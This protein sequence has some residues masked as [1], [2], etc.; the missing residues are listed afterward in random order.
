MEIRRFAERI[1][2]GNTLEDKLLSLDEYQDE[3]PGQALGV[4][5]APG[6]PAALAL[7]QYHQRQRVRFAELRRFHTEKERGLVL[8]FFANHELL[9]LE[10]M[11]LALLRFP[12]APDKFRRGLVQTLRDEQEHVRLYLKRLAQVGVEFGQ[13]PVSDFF[14]RAI[15]PS[16]SP[17]DFVA[18]L[19]LTLEQANL[20]YARHYAA[21]YQH[22]GDEDTARI[23]GRIYRDEIGHVKHGLVWFNRWRDPALSEW[24]AYQGVLQMPL[25]PSRAKGIGFN[26]EGRLEAGLSEAFID[27]LELY[28]RSKGRC[29]SVFWFDPSCESQVI[30]PGFTP[31]RSVRQLAQDLALLPL[32]L[33][34]PDDVVLVPRRPSLDFLR[35]LSRAGFAI[36][37]LVEHPLGSP[38]AGELAQRKLSDLRP[39][40]W[41]PQVERV[42]APLR[43]QL[44]L[45]QGW[46]EQ[47]RALYSKAWSTAALRDFLRICN[48]DWLAD[49]QVVGQACANMEEV[50]AQ[51]ARRAAEGWD[52][53]VV[54][55]AFGAAGQSQVRLA[56]LQSRADQLAQV[57]RLL[58]TQG[59]VVVEPWLD[60]LVDLSAQLEISAPG[61]ARLLGWTRFFTDGRGQYRGSF[62]SQPIA[63][64]DQSIRRFLCGEGRDQR[65]LWRFFEGLGEFLAERLADSGYTGPL[66]VDALIFRQQGRLRL[67]PIVE[68]NPRFTMGRVALGLARRVNAS[69][70]ALWLI[71]GRRQL[72]SAGFAGIAPFAVHLE[73]QFPVEMKGEHISQGVLFTTDPTQAQAFATLLLVGQSLEECKESFAGLPGK[74]GEWMKYC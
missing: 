6:R 7:D 18:R 31:S 72:E 19:S 40:G 21:A 17:L 66:G 10:L 25:T 60:K 23:L 24:E 68:I 48:E 11:A 29:P 61:Q 51:L 57:A 16:P 38:L 53:A 71:L 8:H 14:W 73:R 44:A 52:L 43:E 36:P 15:A 54:K 58:E 67:K 9:A 39:W 22:L 5:A 4:P 33:C 2:F 27:E 64:L 3:V 47:W 42:A 46:R 20:D 62:V 30:R 34:A 69:R 63:G 28:A 70:T 26:R 74:A 55:G 41:S 65:R 35:S 50:G 37:E 56:P 12:E 13:I 59:E 1:L 49:A 45:P 32:Y